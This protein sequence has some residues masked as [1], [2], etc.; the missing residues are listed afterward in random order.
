M[1][2]LVKAHVESEKAAGRDLKSALQSF[3]SR[4]DIPGLPSGIRH[5]RLLK[6]EKPEYLVA[7]CDKAGEPYKFY[8]A[9]ENAYVDIVKAPDGRWRGG[10]GHTVFDANRP[11]RRATDVAASRSDAPLVMRVFKGDLLRIDHTG[12]SKIVMRRASYA[13]D[14]IERIVLQ[15]RRAQRDWKS[16]S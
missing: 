2:D 3:A 15:A 16:S 11:N 1:R 9:G 6:P 5:V 13:P 10:G 14:A 7:V 4:G 12:S 8:S